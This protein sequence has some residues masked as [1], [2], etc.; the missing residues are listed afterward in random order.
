M[1]NFALAG[2]VLNG[3][4]EVWIDNAVA[5]ITVQAV[6]EGMRGALGAG[7]S[8]IVFGA[9]LAPKVQRKLTGQAAVAVGGSAELARGTTIAGHPTI[10]AATQGD[11]TRR[12]MGEGH[13]L[14]EIISAG[15]I[16]VVEPVGA[17]F[18]IELSSSGQLN[19]ATARQVAGASAIGLDSGLSLSAI[20]KLAGDSAVSLAGSGSVAHGMALGG[21]SS[22]AVQSAGDFTRRALGEGHSAI[23]VD[24]GLNLAIQAK[25]SGHSSIAMDGIGTVAHGMGL[26]GT[27]QIDLGMS[28]DFTRWVMVQGRAPIELAP[29]LYS[30]TVK[31]AQLGG[32]SEIEMASIGKLGAILKSPPGAAIIELDSRGAARLGAKAALQGHAA[33]EFYARGDLGKFRYVWLEGTASMGLNAWAE[34]IGVPAIPDYYVEAPK[35][36]MLRVNDE[37]RRFTVPAERRL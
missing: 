13:S 11:F 35:I 33:I 23:V 28:G 18:S 3:D 4:P 31:G 17:T 24:S 20:F 6:G 7:S 29:V 37:T 30:W 19:L 1:Q 5:G 26:S 27:S 22:V 12:A 10:V 21:A 34:K 32:R 25:L 14:V 8:T 15:D 2:G 16:A 9:A 36:R